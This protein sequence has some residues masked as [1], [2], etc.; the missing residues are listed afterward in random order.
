MK[1]NTN[2]Q[3]TFFSASWDAWRV[4]REGKQGIAKRQQERLRALVAYARR[5]S[6]YIADVYRDVPEQLTAVSQLPVMTKAEMMSHFDDWVTDPA[7]TK[8]QV[9]AFITDL[10]LIGHDYLDRYVACTT[11]GSTGIPPNWYGS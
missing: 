11:S 7:V 2:D 3:A 4:V 9:E 1:S 6:R 8:Q 5:H 10:S